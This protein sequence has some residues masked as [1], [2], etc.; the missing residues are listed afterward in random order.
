M[1]L[2]ILNYCTGGVDVIRDVP[3][4]IDNLSYFIEVTL[5]YKESEIEWMTLNYDSCLEFYDYNKNSKTLKY[6]GFGSL[7]CG[8]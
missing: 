3:D 7:D 1:R 4:D 6:T 5:G 2:I 8:I